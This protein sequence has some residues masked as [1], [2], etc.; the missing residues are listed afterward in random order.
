M[1][2]EEVGDEEE[3]LPPLSLTRNLDELEH[4]ALLAVKQNVLRDFVIFID[5]PF[6]S[7]SVDALNRN[8][9]L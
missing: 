9:L 2:A 7:T 4:T 3:V 5:G 6:S 8:F 1:K